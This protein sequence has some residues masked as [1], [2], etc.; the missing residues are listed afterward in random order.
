MRAD[1][2][3]GY[4]ISVRCWFLS[5]V[6]LLYLVLCRLVVVHV[7]PCVVFQ[8]CSCSL[9]LFKQDLVVQ[10]W[11]FVSLSCVVC[12]MASPSFHVV[13]SNSLVELRRSTLQL[14]DVAVV[15]TFGNTATFQDIWDDWDHSPAY[16]AHACINVLNTS[17]KQAEYIHGLLDM[18][19]THK[20]DLTDSDPHHTERVLEGVVAALLVHTFLSGRG[21]CTERQADV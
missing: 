20:D 1:R 16:H 14:N 11:R 3:L 4:G 17:L 12:S 6:R 19:N 9:V 10:H 15:C 2:K 18:P 21:S 8:G 7:R 13:H 5:C